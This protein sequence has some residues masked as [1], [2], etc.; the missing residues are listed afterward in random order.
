MTIGMMQFVFVEFKGDV[1]ESDVFEELL[2]LRSAGMIRLIDFLV[3]EK[4]QDGFLWGSEISD[5]SGEIEIQ[6]G[7]LLG[8]LIELD[9]VE[10]DLVAE[11]DQAQAISKADLGLSPLDLNHIVH[12]IPPGTSA[13]LALVEHVW[14]RN[15]KDAV[16]AGGGVMLAQG[17]VEPSGLALLKTELEAVIEAAAVVEIAELKASDT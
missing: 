7:T 5:L 4:D 11:I 10:S 13:I 1:F 12:T 3:L 9:E 14:S 16:Q 17:L 6:Y 2:A 8:K 15:L